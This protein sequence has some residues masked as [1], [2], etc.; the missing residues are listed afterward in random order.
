MLFFYSWSKCLYDINSIKNNISKKSNHSESPSAERLLEVKNMTNTFASTY[1]SGLGEIIPRLLET[2]LND[3]EIIK[4]FDGLIIYKTKQIFNES[5]F[6]FFNN[7]FLMFG[8]SNVNNEQSFNSAL[9]DFF[10][11]LKINFENIFYNINLKKY[12]TFKILG[13]DKN[14]PV[15]IDYSLIKP[16]ENKIEN[17]CN[18][19]VAFKKHDLDFIFMRRTEGIMLFLFKL[20]YNRITEKQLQPGAIRPE[21]A[22]FLA[23]ISDISKSD[24]VIDPFCGHGSIPKEIV[25][26][27]RFNMIFASDI[28]E[29]LINKLKLEY[30][31]NK[32]NL[33]IKQRDA[34]NLSYFKDGFFDKI[35]TDPPW[36]IYNSVNDEFVSFYEKM[37]SEF[38]RI[39]KL[40]GCCVVL[41]GNLKD[42][43][44]ALEKFPF[45]IV[46]KYHILV[47]G[48]K[49]NIYKLIKT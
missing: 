22:Y 4:N 20:T 19:S 12:R 31:K 29:N 11:H 21:L 32:K 25:K 9:S 13:I 43:E 17:L 3:V 6:P 36:N 1:I 2:K 37:L 33:F 23:W 15:S 49:A 26:N 48:K 34:L 42:F 47:N 27:F 7:T 41:M 46:G 39:L 38:Y 44:N 18:L 40:N 30:K 28:D 35:I 16:L 5:L 8:Y 24:I 45:K 10:K 14:Q